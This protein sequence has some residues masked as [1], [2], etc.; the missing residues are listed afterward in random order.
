MATGRGARPVTTTRDREAP[1]DTDRE[2]TGLTQGRQVTRRQHGARRSSNDTGRNGFLPTSH[3]WS[4]EDTCG[5]RPRDVTP[6]CPEPGSSTREPSPLPA[7]HRMRACDTGRGTERGA[8]A[9]DTSVGPARGSGILPPD[10]TRPGPHLALQVEVDERLHVLEISI[11]LVRGLL[12]KE[13]F[14]GWRGQEPTEIRDSD[15][16]A[17]VEGGPRAPGWAPGLAG[18]GQLHSSALLCTHRPQRPGEREEQGATGTGRRPRRKVL[19]L[20]SVCPSGLSAR[21]TTGEGTTTRRPPP[22]H[23]TSN[24]RGPE[25]GDLHLNADPPVRAG[26]PD[27]PRGPSGV[28]SMLRGASGGFTGPQRGT[29]GLRGLQTLKG[30]SGHLRGRGHYHLLKPIRVCMCVQHG[31]SW[32]APTHVPHSGSPR[33]SVSRSCAPHCLPWGPTPAVLSKPRSQALL[34]SGV[35]GPPPTI[36]ICRSAAGGTRD[37]G[38]GPHLQHHGDITALETPSGAPGWPGTCLTSYR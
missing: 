8:Q 2:D 26:R 31:S 17:D 22:R 29:G 9:R 37:T 10:P 27:G 7:Q 3:V 20:T 21:A 13:T 18:P 11:E 14:V 23:C 12:S 19:E 36:P 35:L 25:A 5:H 33:P 15:P 1:A 16:G 4:H 32:S 28:W 30:P 24:P 6:T 34:F 38:R